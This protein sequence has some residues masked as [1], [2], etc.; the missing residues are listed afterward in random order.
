[1]DW[2][3]FIGG[4][5]TTV[6]HVDGEIGAQ[7]GTQTAVG[8][9]LVVDYFGRVVPFGIGAG[10]YGK[11]VPGTKLDAETASFTAVINHMDD[12]VRNPDAISVERLS[13]VW[14][15]FSLLRKGW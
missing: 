7:Q 1:M 6:F 13:P 5:L 8:A 4:T 12:P 2:D 11:Q 15:G 9:V 3:N 14:H 10:G